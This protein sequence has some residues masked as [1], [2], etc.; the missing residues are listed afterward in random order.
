MRVAFV[1]LFFEMVAIVRCFMMGCCENMGLAILSIGLSGAGEINIF[2]VFRIVPFS[3]GV[4]YAVLT[5]KTENSVL[6]DRKQ[7]FLMK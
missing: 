7:W 3:N 5:I 6:S 2:L 1:L 4:Y